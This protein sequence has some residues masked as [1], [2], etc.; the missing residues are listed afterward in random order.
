[1]QSKGSAGMISRTQV[2]ELF[3]ETTDNLVEDFDLVDFL[4]TLTGN[5]ASASDAASAGVVVTD[6][7]DRLRHMAS[8]SEHE[9]VL[10]LLELQD[11]PCLD[12]IMS[13]M[14]MVNVDLGQVDD[15]WPLFAPTAREA[16]YQSAHVFPLKV[17]RRTIGA[18][19]VL[20]VDA[21]RRDPDELRVVQG[22]ADLAAIAIVQERN[23][24]RSQTVADQLQSALLSRIV[25]EQAK[26]ALARSQSITLTDAF[27]V[28]RTTAR[29][30]GVKVD[31]IA[32]AV[33]AELETTPR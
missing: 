21:V 26:G 33:I 32:R 11:G 22:L 18:L 20:S 19:S 13:G 29:S 5:A 23:G 31:D 10:Q 8:S 25:V 12:V 9:R 30:I 6:S 15:R 3:L 28:M 4:H 1:M 2:L 17:R 24:D 14:A 27:D 7:A 16:G